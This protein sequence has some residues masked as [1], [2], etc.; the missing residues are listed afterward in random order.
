MDFTSILK[1][2]P[3]TMLEKWLAFENEDEFTSRV[4]FTLRDMYTIVRG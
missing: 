2:E 3:L 1:Y 4:Y